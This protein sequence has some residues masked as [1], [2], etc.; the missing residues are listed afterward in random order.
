LR[1]RNEREYAFIVLFVVLVAMFLDGADLGCL[2]CVANGRR[3]GWVVLTRCCVVRWELDSE[4]GGVYDL[5]CADL[6]VM[7]LVMFDKGSMRRGVLTRWYLHIA[8][9]SFMLL[10]LFFPLICL[11]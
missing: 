9:F 5:V 7:L 4:H 10:Y 11:G 3:W 2:C 8:C 1:I 6:V